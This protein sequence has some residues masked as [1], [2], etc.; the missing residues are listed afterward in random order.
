MSEVTSTEHICTKI[1][2]IDKGIHGTLAYRPRFARNAHRPSFR[3]AIRSC[4]Y[5]FN[6][7]STNIKVDSRFGRS[8][9]GQ[10]DPVNGALRCPSF[11]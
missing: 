5:G 4:G 9:A 11:P 1:L 10:L 8:D 7:T 6:W 2:R 3:H